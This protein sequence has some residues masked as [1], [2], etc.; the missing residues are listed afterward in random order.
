MGC[1]V[2]PSRK[3]KIVCAHSD[4]TVL[5]DLTTASL[6]NLPWNRVQLGRFGAAHTPRV[7]RHGNKDAYLTAIWIY[8][9]EEKTVSIRRK[10]LFWFSHYDSQ[11]E[12]LVAAIA[13]QQKYRLEEGMIYV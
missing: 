5:F 10:K 2:Y 11:D 7:I 9:P 3:G 13:W 8:T 6:S 1:I 4:P 12:A